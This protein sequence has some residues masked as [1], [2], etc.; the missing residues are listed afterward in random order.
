M[1][2]RTINYEFSHGETNARPADRS[3]SKITAALD[4]ATIADLSPMKI[5]QMP[6]DEMMR[7]IEA[8]RLPL[9]PTGSAKHLE[10]H[11][12]K[13]LER[14]VHLA[15]RCCHNRRTASQSE[16]RYQEITAE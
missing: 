2:K 5:S 8:A 11:D 16:R 4:D 7:V 6:R 1:V 14:L 3:F 9:L 10:F 13:T 12:R 15:R